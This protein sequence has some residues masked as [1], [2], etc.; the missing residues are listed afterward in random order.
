M[1]QVEINT[2][3]SISRK[4]IVKPVKNILCGHKYDKH[5]IEA[6]LKQNPICRCPLVGCP[7]PRQEG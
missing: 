1:T 3:C 2:V 5:S 7:V 4:E 6:L